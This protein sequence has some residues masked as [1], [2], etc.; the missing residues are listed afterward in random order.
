MKNDIER[1]LQQWW[2]MGTLLRVQIP[3]TIDELMGRFAGLDV[4]GR[5]KM[6]S[7]DGREYTLAD[8]EIISAMPG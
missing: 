1:Q 3:G 4:F 8:A 2:S 7:N 6:T 5:L